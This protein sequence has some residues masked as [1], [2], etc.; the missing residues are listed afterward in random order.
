MC[1]FRGWRDLEWAG[2]SGKKIRLTFYFSGVDIIGWQKKRAELYIFS[3][4]HKKYMKKNKNMFQILDYK[5]ACHIYEKCYTGKISDKNSVMFNSYPLGWMILYVV[6][7]V[8]ERCYN[9]TWEDK[10]KCNRAKNTENLYKMLIVA[11]EKWFFRKL[12]KGDRTIKGIPNTNKT[13]D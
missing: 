7:F 6:C 1:I 11:F 9:K 3:Q 8:Y 4:T 10:L 2:K 12:W 13:M 5:N